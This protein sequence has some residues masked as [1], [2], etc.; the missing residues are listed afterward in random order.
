MN[1]SIFSNIRRLNIVKSETIIFI[2]L[3]ING[4]TPL[5][6]TIQ[7]NCT[8]EYTW[9]KLESS[10]NLSIGRAQSNVASSCGLMSS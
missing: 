1:D 2:V 3:F 5:D 10:I 6:S 7:Q 8:N 4:E 9:N